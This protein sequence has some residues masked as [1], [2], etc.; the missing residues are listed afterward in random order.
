MRSVSLSSGSVN[1]EFTRWQEN[2]NDYEL[3]GPSEWLP[4]PRK[5]GIF[6][7]A[8]A[9]PDAGARR[10]HGDCFGH[11]ERGDHARGAA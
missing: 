2:S 9:C 11:L 7:G 8:S 1:N 6:N 10:S 4:D 5:R 3:A